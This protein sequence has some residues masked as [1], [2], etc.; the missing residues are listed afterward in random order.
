MSAKDRVCT[1][2]AKPRC[3]GAAFGFAVRF[4]AERQ[5]TNSLQTGTT[6]GGMTALAEYRTLRL[7][8]LNVS[9]GSIP[10]LTTPLPRHLP[11]RNPSEHNRIGRR[12]ATHPCGAMD[13]AGHFAGRV[14]PRNRFSHYVDHAGVAVDA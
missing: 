4:T 1:S 14:Q 9:F 5:V 8:A 3:A 7:A 12:V 10:A 11:P 6:H 2:E 13:A